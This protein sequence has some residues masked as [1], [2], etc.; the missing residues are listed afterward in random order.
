MWYVTPHTILC[1]AEV[2]QMRVMY[3]DQEGFD[4]IEQQVPEPVDVTEEQ[5]ES[6]TFI[7]IEN[8]IPQLSPAEVQPW[9]WLSS[10]ARDMDLLQET[11]WNKAVL[12]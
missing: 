3:D 10:T 12:P 4:G 7:T 6:P 11:F 9:Y 1:G 8:S 2:V 5:D